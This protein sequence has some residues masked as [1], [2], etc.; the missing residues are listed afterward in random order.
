MLH[1]CYHKTTKLGRSNNKDVNLVSAPTIIFQLTC[2]SC[3]FNVD[4]HKHN[5]ISIL[6]K[7]RLNQ[8][9]SNGGPSTTR[10]LLRPLLFFSGTPESL[11]VRASDTRYEFGLNSNSKSSPGRVWFIPVL[12]LVQTGLVQVQTGM[13]MPLL[14]PDLVEFRPG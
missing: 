5:C 6:K 12:I 10:G 4:L 9:F 13:D 2:R 7:Q 11:A 14:T 8:W 1:K 3:S